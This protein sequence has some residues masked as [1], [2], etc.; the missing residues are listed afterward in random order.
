MERVGYQQITWQQHEAANY[1]RSTT[2]GDDAAL[3]EIGIATSPESLLSQVEAAAEVARLLGI[4]TRTTR[5]K[6]RAKAH[7]YYA[8][9]FNQSVEPNGLSDEEREVLAAWVR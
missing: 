2:K 4:D 8:G 1:G 3:E 7:L 9:E 6:A 5:E